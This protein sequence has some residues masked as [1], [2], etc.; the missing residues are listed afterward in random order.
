VSR[1]GPKPIPLEV[2]FWPKVN[3][4]ETCWLWTA[5]RTPA[6]YGS[7]FAR[8]P[9][10]IEYAHRIAWQLV[11][12]P[13]PS[14]LVIDHLCRVRHCVNPEHM[15]LVTRGENNRRGIARER[16]IA[17]AKTVTHCKRGHPFDE[18]N[19]HIATTGKRICRTCNRER[20]R[21]NAAL[22]RDEI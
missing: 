4:T 7:F 19:T 12:G 9:K 3:K 18:T 5:G 1:T 2:R 6:G 22:A 13:L 14:D 16:R 10:R 21:R 20:Q 17:Q 8:E 15:E 11:N